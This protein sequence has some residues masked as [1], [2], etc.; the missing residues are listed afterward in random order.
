MGPAMILFH[1][2]TI[3]GAQLDSLPTM[4]VTY[5]HPNGPVGQVFKS[6]QTDQQTRNVGIVGLGTASILCYSKSGEHWTF[7]EID[8]HV[9]AIARNPQFFTYMSRC[10]VKPKVVIGDARLTM[11]REPDR[12]YSLIV[13]DAFSSDAIPV[14][15]LTREALATY[16]RILNDD[17]I[18]LVHI[19]NRRLDLEPVVGALARDAH[20]YALIGKRDSP[21]D[22]SRTYEYGSDWVV[23]SKREA[24]LVP[25]AGNPRWKAVRAGSQLWTDDYSNLFSVIKW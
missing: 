9:E 14:H 19:S 23:L 5:Y 15:L 6:L 18:L 24:D 7:F 21:D 20:M 25:L 11:A 4:P 3:H 22:R 13:L 12:K 8:P 2:S 17:G 1:G 16:R 10:A